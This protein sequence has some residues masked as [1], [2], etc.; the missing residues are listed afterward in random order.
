MLTILSFAQCAKDI[1]VGCKACARVLPEYY[2]IKLG[3]SSFYICCESC[4]DRLCQIFPAPP[5]SSKPTVDRYVYSRLRK[6]K[7]QKEAV[8]VKEVSVNPLIQ[9]PI[10]QHS[11]L[12]RAQVYKAP[13]QVY[14]M[15]ERIAEQDEPIQTLL[16]GLHDEAM[17]EDQKQRRQRQK[18]E[19][20]TPTAKDQQE[21]LHV[22]FDKMSK[23]QND[24]T[25]LIDK[26][27]RLRQQQ[28]EYRQ[29]HVQQQ[30]KQAPTTTAEATAKEAEKTALCK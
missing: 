1:I 18:D 24:K 2:L 16:L 22:R 8:Q 10:V 28:T 21:D 19:V 4:T 30:K 26:I 29:K 27:K 25:G 3:S 12:Q 7:I 13:E 9:L 11:S 6:F 15:Y 5:V 20:R 23:E 14:D 17:Q